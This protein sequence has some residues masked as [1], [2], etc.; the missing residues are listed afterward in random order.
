VAG[1]IRWARYWSDYSQR[2]QDNPRRATEA[3]GFGKSTRLQEKPDGDRHR[4]HGTYLAEDHA[5][6]GQEAGVV[7]GAD[8]AGDASRRRIHCER[9]RSG[10]RGAG[11]AVTGIRRDIPPTR[12]FAGSEARLPE[13]A[14]A[15]S[16]ACQV[17]VRA[18]RAVEVP[19]VSIRVSC[20]GRLR[21]VR[22]V[23]ARDIV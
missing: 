8:V 15:S 4:P 22:N 16:A 14:G 19:C 3:F 9:L 2:V 5:R 20:R 12:P 21:E 10:R 18:R 6:R 7:A 23:A 1:G 13:R 17:G 11:K